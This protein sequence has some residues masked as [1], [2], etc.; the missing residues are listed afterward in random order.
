MT[1]IFDDEA[2]HPGDHHRGRPCVVVQ[3]KTGE[4]D[5]YQAVQL[6]WSSALPPQRAKPMQGTSEA[7]CRDAAARQVRDAVDAE[8]AASPRLVL[9]T[10]SPS[11]SA[12][13]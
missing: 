1:Q 13:T 5:G 10:S 9:A 11:T 2:G 12:C 7:A 4:R 3:R 6:G 8:D